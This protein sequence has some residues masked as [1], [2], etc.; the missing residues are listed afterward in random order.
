M[1]LWYVTIC[2]KGDKMYICMYKYP[3][4]FM[5]ILTTLVVFRERK[6]LAGIRGGREVY[7]SLYTIL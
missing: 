4:N 3:K 7:H 5:K 1:D 6:R 2:V